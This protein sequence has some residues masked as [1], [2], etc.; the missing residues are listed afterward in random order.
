MAD[1][2]KKVV[3]GRWGNGD[4]RIEDRVEY[5]LVPPGEYEARYR[6]HTTFKLHGGGEKLRAFFV[7]SD[8]GEAF[9]TAVPCFWGVTLTKTG[10][11]AGTRTKFLRE[12]CRL[13]PDYRPSRNDRIPMSRF[14]G[15]AFQ[16]RVV[17]VDKD[18]KGNSIPPQLHYSK[19][20]E[21]QKVLI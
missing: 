16:I 20:A 5:P 11:K 6:N 15:K 7:I 17:T 12:F 1:P 4:G 13:F 9:C 8:T 19:I 2:V 18:R 10:F 21:I 3:K 14:K